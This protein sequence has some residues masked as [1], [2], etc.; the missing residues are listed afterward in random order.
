MCNPLCVLLC[1]CIVEV[2]ISTDAYLQLERIVHFTG[3]LHKELSKMPLPDLDYMFWVFIPEVG[4][5]PCL[6]TIS[7]FLMPFSKFG[8]CSYLWQ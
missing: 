7:T 4:V 1:Q 5:I 2:F 3:R 6:Y 8:A